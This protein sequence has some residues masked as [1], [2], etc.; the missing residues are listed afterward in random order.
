[1]CGLVGV[2]HLTGES[3]EADILRRMTDV[4]AFR[5]PDGQGVYTDGPIGLGHRRLAVIDLSPAGQQPMANDAGELVLVYNGE[6]YNF[7]E[8]R[9]ELEA[10]GH[11]FRSRTDTEVVL[12]AYEVWG[13]A[14]VER[15]NGMFALA[16]WDRRRRRLWLARDRYGI[17][18]LYWYHRAG[19]LLFA[20][21]I[22]AI[23]EHPRVSRAVCYPALNEYFTFQ[24]IFSE[25][26]LFEGI[27]L[28][29]PGCTLTVA[30]DG[31]S[32]PVIRRY[33]EYPAPRS[34]S[35][36]S[37]SAC[38]EGL[39]H[40]LAQAVT[41]QLVSDVPVGAYL[42]GG[43]DSGS[44]AALAAQ[45]LPRLSTFTGGFDLT[46]ASGLELGF[47]ERPQA[48]MLANLLKTEHYEVVMHAGDMAWVLPTLIWHLEDLRVGQCYPNYYTARL[49]SKFVKVVLSGIGGDELFGGYPWRYYRGMNSAG[50]QEYLQRY[51]QS[52]QRLVPDEEKPRLFTGDTQRHLKGHSAFDVFCSVF[53]GW[54]GSFDTNEDYLAA[55][56]YFE[57]KTFLHGLLVVEDKLSMAHS[58]ETRVPFLD[59]DL[60]DFAMQMPVRYKVRN[61]ERTI[62]IDENLFGKCQRYEL[63]TSD[64]KAILRQAVSS[65]IPR[66]VTERIKQGFSAPDAS[67]FRGESIDYLNGLLR[68]R[69]A[70]LYHFLNPRYV[71]EVLDEHCSGRANHRLL[72]WSLL[73]FEWWCRTFL[74]GG[75]APQV[76]PRRVRMAA[77]E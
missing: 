53:D 49:A 62:R 66:D 69:K 33:W 42:S 36:L 20:S 57:L 27:R 26:T 65:L 24:N 43:I 54:R 63:Q 73:S 61:L 41:R 19:L 12:R 10:A 37:E 23:L 64:G 35:D 6:V 30:L 38:A 40:L 50:R 34:S 22:K 1:M 39:Q 15:F 72:I 28:L 8:L 11:R 32:E 44:I 31:N 18:P 47:D 46:S 74:N 9:A 48:E 56:L 17:K 4:I 68:D 45:H 29:P 13:E 70:M 58:L 67:W 75:K 16:I 5:G 14:C 71:A 3:V 59:H 52:W 55:S 60:V 51:Y 76:Q 21:E 7:Q 2:C 77:R 25:L